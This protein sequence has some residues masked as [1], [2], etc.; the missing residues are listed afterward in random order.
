M[1][2]R[3]NY[4]KDHRDMQP[5]ACSIAVFAAGHV[6]LIERANMPYKGLWTLPGGKIDPGETAEECV[7]RELW[8]ET[9]LIVGDPTTVMVQTIG[10]ADN[11]FRLAVF[12]VRHTL[13]TPVPSSE[14]ADWDWVPL[15]EIV[16]YKTTFGLGRIVKKCAEHLD[17]LAPHS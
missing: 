14:V 10:T 9:G 15:E 8:E 17:V 16:H 1:S 6:L 2:A 11:R 4:I 5:N 3:A 7:V 12:A 13:V